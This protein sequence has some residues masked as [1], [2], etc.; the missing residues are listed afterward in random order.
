[1]SVVDQDVARL[2]DR[3]GNLER[4]QT[5][6]QTTIDSLSSLVQAQT[7]EMRQRRA[8]G[9]ERLTRLELDL[10]ALRTEL[11]AMRLEISD[12]KDRQQFATPV[13][14]AAAGTQAAAGGSPR[15]LYDAAYQD[16]SRGNL[17]LA[18]MGFEEV[19]ARYPTSELA[20]NAQYWIGEVYYDRKDYGAAL[21]EFRKVEANHPTGDKVPAALLKIGMSLQ[22]MGESS[23]ARRA[24]ESLVERFPST[25][26]ARLARDKLA[27]E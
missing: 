15:E 13:P 21:E 25:E 4:A 16:L 27:Q 7:D 14:T 17:D 9:E 10:Q 20:D 26:E 19:L 6:L 5:R 24:F 3:V 8:G 11:E 23:D 22:E 2:Q 1:M 18:L 12:L